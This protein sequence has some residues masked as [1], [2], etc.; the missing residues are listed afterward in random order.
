MF[1]VLTIV[2][3]LLLISMVAGSVLTF[4]EGDR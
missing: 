2:G 1:T 4:V 3:A